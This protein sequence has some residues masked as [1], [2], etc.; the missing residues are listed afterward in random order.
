MTRRAARNPR[1]ID[2]ANEA[3]HASC[4]AHAATSCFP[5][6]SDTMP[7][8]LAPCAVPAVDPALLETLR[9][10]HWAMIDA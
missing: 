8:C 5:M 4:S 6:Q 3:F 7:I 9:T 1:G 10:E 2:D